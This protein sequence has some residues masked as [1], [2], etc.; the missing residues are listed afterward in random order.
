MITERSTGK[1]LS[2]MFQGCIQ[3]GGRLLLYCINRDCTLL[4]NSYNLISYCETLRLALLPNQDNQVNL[5]QQ[6]N[7][8]IYT[9]RLTSAFMQYHLITTLIQP[10]YLPNLN[11]IKHLQQKLKQTIYKLYSYL[12]DKGVSAEAR[13]AFKAA[14]QEAQERID[15]GQI[16][17]LINTIGR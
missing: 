1:G 15:Q 16:N 17:G 10:L 14:A 12:K 11:L 9:L 13:K 6:D 3:K 4:A 5:F 7:A 2:Q 8:L